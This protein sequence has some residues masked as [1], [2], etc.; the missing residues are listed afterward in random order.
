MENRIQTRMMRMRQLTD[1]TA[2]SRAYLYQ[3]INE[4]S[5]PSGRLISAGI[6]VWEK[7]EVDAWLDQ[8]MGVGSK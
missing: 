4:G 2:L 5:F 8:Q 3:K 6:R 1:Y 7:A